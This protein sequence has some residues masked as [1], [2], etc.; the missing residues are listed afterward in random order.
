M[1]SCGCNGSQNASSAPMH[2]GRRHKSRK[3]KGGDYQQYPGSSSYGSNMQ[4]QSFNGNGS[5]SS[6]QN[7]SFE[8][9][10]NNQSDVNGTINGK[11]E[12][13]FINDMPVNGNNIKVRV[14][15]GKIVE[16]RV[17]PPS[18]FSLFGGKKR[19]HRKLRGGQYDA[20]GNP[21]TTAQDAVKKVADTAQGAMSSFLEFVKPGQ[22]PQTGG[23]RRRRTVKLSM[24]RGRGKTRARAGGRTKSRSKSRTGGKSRRRRR[25][26]KRD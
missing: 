10:L 3:I 20:S 6:M 22:D 19:R 17:E 8:G 21:L 15:N 26:G 25:G 5:N 14:Q 11:I 2:G 4:R 23:R 9:S 16:G 13:G 24:G 7:P 18:M 1:S 12:N